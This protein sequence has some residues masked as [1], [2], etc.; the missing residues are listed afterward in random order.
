MRCFA[1][2]ALALS[3]SLSAQAAPIELTQ[4]GRLADSAGTPI[5]GSHT[6]HFRLFA[7]ASGGVAVWEE[8]QSVE[9]ANGYYAVS[10]G[11]QT[12]LESALFT[13][14][15]LYLEVGVDNGAPLGR[16]R[17]GSVP[18]ALNAATG[19]SSGALLAA[20][21][22][23]E[24]SGTLADS[25]GGGATLT[26][27][28]GGVSQ[29]AAG[30]SLGAVDFAGGVLSAAEPNPIGDA[31]NLTVEARILPSTAGTGTETLLNKTGAYRL[32][33]IDGKPSFAV[34][35]TGGS[36][37]ITH[38]TVAPASEWSAVSAYYNG[39]TAAVILDG[40]AVSQACA[41]GPVQPT[42]GGSFFLGA[43]AA[44][45]T[46]P[47]AGS[48]DEVRLWSFAPL[49]AAGVSVSVSDVPVCSAQ[50]EG[51]ITYTEGV[52]MGCDGSQWQML[53][54]DNSSKTYRFTH[55]GK[56]GRT[57]PS[58]SQCNSEYTGTPLASSVTVS[59]GI[60]LWTVPQTGTYEITAWGAMGGEGTY[61]SGQHRVRR[62][63][64]GAMIQGRF[65]LTQGEVIKV[66]VGQQGVRPAQGSYGH[67]PG[68]G[69]GGSF[70]VRNDNSILVIAGGG[71]GGGDPAYGQ[72][73]GGHG[74][75]ETSGERVVDHPSYA[76]NGG[77]SG[78]GGAANQYAGAG[79]G[80]S[81][82][83]AASG[84]V[85]A[86]AQ[87]FLNGGIGGRAS[88]H[89]VNS[90]GGFGGGGHGELCGGGGGGYSGGGA[91]CGWSSYG[92]AG[93]GGSYNAGTNQVML[94]GER[95]NDGLVEIVFLR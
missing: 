85:A 34:I 29:G 87:S 46:T 64:R 2:A 86:Y 1:L 76:A 25:S 11:V 27:S 17:L 67:Q 70:V 13:G 22:L 7:E 95:L 83:G 12:A 80:Y 72:E 62:G 39:S 88:A 21:E 50:N 49:G 19:G 16:T 40:S 37:T 31:P 30:H 28:A 61:N 44:S 79:A 93:G 38:S 77:S 26:A 81:G 89:S 47:F 15:P 3:F 82:N 4:Q 68:G 8:S 20:W 59:G 92:R 54:G 41:V 14:E 42:A 10:L 32:E 35:G 75:I 73:F 48:L 53:G 90:E 23:D 9:L 78:G 94:P 36:C 63:G 57:G 18:Y 71:G 65:E 51:Q 84:N 56:T 55:C 74:R 52:F 45:P 6:L 43:D 91:A 69:G 24:A 66:L 33:R 60:Q 5:N 58:Q